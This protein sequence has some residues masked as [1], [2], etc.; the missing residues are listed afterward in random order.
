MCDHNNYAGDHERSAGKDNLVRV[1]AVHVVSEMLQSDSPTYEKQDAEIPLEIIKP[2]NGSGDMA[3]EQLVREAIREGEIDSPRVPKSQINGQQSNEIVFENHGAEG[4]VY[5]IVVCIIK[6]YLM[7]IL[8]CYHNRTHTHTRRGSKLS[9]PDNNVT[10][11]H[12]VSELLR[13]DYNTQDVES[14]MKTIEHGNGSGDMVNG[15]PLQE[16]ISE[17]EIDSPR[18]PKSQMNGQKSNEFVFE[19]HGAEGY[20]F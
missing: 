8:M 9:G 14:P 13:L 7:F 4:Y 1:T 19:N 15:P 5:I 11:A 16:A 6:F 3:N 2:G 10:T 20:V 17:E 18:V 12:V